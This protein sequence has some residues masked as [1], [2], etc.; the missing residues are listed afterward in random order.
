MTERDLLVQ[1]AA[2]KRESY[3]NLIQED[4]RI[5]RELTTVRNFI[6]HLNELLVIA[7]LDPI[8]LTTQ[9]P[10]TRIARIGNRSDDMPPRQQYYENMN[11]SEAANHVLRS[12]G[13]AMHIDEI[14]QCVW[15]IQ[16]PGD[17]KRGKGSLTRTLSSAVTAKRMRRPRPGYYELLDSSNGT[18]AMPISELVGDR[19]H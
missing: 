6:E 5:S 14:V 9:I 8:P 17:L 10:H 2:E 16:N 13:H 7:G 18:M 11:L 12:N 3:N 19:A 4:A 15:Q 1:L